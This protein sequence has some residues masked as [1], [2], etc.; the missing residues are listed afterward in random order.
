MLLETGAELLG[1]SQ[2][3]IG[4]ALEEMVKAEDV[5]VEASLSEQEAIYLPPF[6]FSEEGV[7]KCLT[8]MLK[9]K[10]GSISTQRICL[11]ASSNAPA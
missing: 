8:A 1:V 6:Y 7:A 10:G 4:S 3:L 9:H 2:E 11:N 5:I